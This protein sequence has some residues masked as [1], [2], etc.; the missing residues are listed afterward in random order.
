MNNAQNHAQN[1]P[2][3]PDDPALH[4]RASELFALLRTLAPGDRTARLAAV[5]DDALRAEVAS[6]LA[7]D[8][9][10]EPDPEPSPD[11]FAPGSALGPY[12]IVRRLGRG[13]TGVVLLAD[14]TEPVRRRVAV[15]LVPHAM[16]DAGHAAR[17]EFERRALERTDHPGIP[18]VLDAGRAPTGV[19]F[20]AMEF[21]DGPPVTAFCNERGLSLPD[22]V[23]LVAEIAGAVQHAHQRGLIHRDLKPSNILVASDGA[24]PQPKIVDFGIARSLDRDDAGSLTCGQP[25]GTLA[26]MPPEQAAGGPVDTR[27]DVYALGAVLYELIAQR[28]PLIFDDPARALELIR[29]QTPLPASRARADA[30]GI[31]RAM[32]ADLDR[33]LACA[34]D[35][36]PARRYATADAFAQDLRRVLCR[37]PVAARAQTPVYRFARLVER[38]KAASAAAALAALAVGVGLA[39]LGIGYTEA[40]RQRAI[41]ADRAD[42]LSA[43]NRFLID[44]LLAA[45]SPDEI[46]IDTPAVQLLDRAAARIGTRFPD[47]PLL[48][49]ELHHTLG[50]SYTQ[51]SAF[52]QAERELDR[53]AALASETAGPES[54]QAVRSRL[55][56]ASLTAYRQR[57]DPAIAAFETLIPLG[58]RV[59]GPDDPALH[60]AWNDAGVALDSAGR[61]AEGG[62]LIERS[63]KAR[64]RTLGPNDPL[65]LQ[66]L[67]NLAQVRDAQ[68]DTEGALALMIEAAGVAGAMPD[69]PAVL[70]MGLHNNIGAT[71]LDL[72]RHADAAPHL[73]KAASMAADWFGPE[74]P[75]TLT[76]MSNLASLRA[77]LGDAPGAIAAFEHIVRARTALMG[78]DV[79]DTLIAR[80][81]LWSAHLAAG[82]ADRAEPGFAQLLRDCSRALGEAHWLTG[83]TLVSHAKALQSLGRVA[84]ARDAAATGHAVFLALLGP[85]HARTTSAAA[86]LDEL[87]KATTP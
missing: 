10:D 85:D 45:I 18:K 28:P 35:K 60:A 69:A 4:A 57:F 33:V 13:A 31:S 22:R 62:V 47:R 41:A 6:L 79:Y 68:G 65:V 71:Y 70:L 46:P 50:R 66:T 1:H 52:D 67:S 5:V 58:E 44:D 43:V 17:F 20:I 61:H 27:A 23:A 37:E 73:E 51:L 19:P 76:I 36:D 83:A 25:I 38:R 2:E 64:R 54:P 56:S 3:S 34:L 32:W 77:D 48:A 55:A 81:G 42:T 82:H 12:T 49:A 39:G 24:R 7:Y 8:L 11:P 72:G 26:S 63:L 14:Q 40:D 74:D 80:H 75:T 78:P 86:L 29:T 53:A 84:D 30:G 9:P 59:L 15:K 87:Q 21:V 16:L